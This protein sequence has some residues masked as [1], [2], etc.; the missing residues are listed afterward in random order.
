M[1]T[2]HGEYVVMVNSCF[3][4]QCPIK[5][6]DGRHDTGLFLLCSSTQK[7]Q[8]EINVFSCKLISPT[9]Q[10]EIWTVNIYCLFTRHAVTVSV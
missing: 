9:M 8:F 10:V 6:R 2:L 3:W 1:H 4:L 5:S 7:A